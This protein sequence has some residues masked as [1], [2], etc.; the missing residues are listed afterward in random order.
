MEKNQDSPGVQLCVW[1]S[2]TAKAN[3]IWDCLCRGEAGLQCTSRE[4][5]GESERIGFGWGTWVHGWIHRRPG[6]IWLFDEPSGLGRQSHPEC[7]F[8]KWFPDPCLHKSTCNVC[9]KY[10]FLCSSLM[11]WKDSG[12]G[13]HIRT[14]SHCLSHSWSR[15][16]KLAAQGLLAW[17]WLY[18]KLDIPMDSS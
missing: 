3:H 15:D 1:S 11:T 16:L 7:L 6:H 8:S 10:G 18:W 4:L 13:T 5:S 17:V 14:W 9:I 12:K 2:G